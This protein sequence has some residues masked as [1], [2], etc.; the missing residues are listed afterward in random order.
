MFFGTDKKENVEKPAPQKE[1]RPIPSLISQGVRITGNLETDGEVQIDGVL[2][3]DIKTGTLTI[4]ETAVVTGEI[5]ADQ[6]TVRGKITGRIRV[7]SVLLTKTAR[8]IGDIWHQDLAMEAGAFLE[9]HC[10]R[11]EI[12]PVAKSPAAPV[13]AAGA[14]AAPVK[15]DGA[16]AAPEITRRPPEETLPLVASDNKPLA[17]DKDKLVTKKAVRA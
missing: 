6:A 7:R 15:T 1:D 14:V 4:G 12:P 8:V 9:G 11:V 16:A 17:A 3:G 5:I 2:E 13:K 10:K